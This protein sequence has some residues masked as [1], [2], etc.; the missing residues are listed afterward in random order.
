MKTKIVKTALLKVKKGSINIFIL[1]L[2]MQ[3]YSTFTYNDE[4]K[5]NTPII[6]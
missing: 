2:Y 4:I 6:K 3:K 5:S 1:F